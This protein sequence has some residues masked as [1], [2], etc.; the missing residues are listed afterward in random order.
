[1][2]EKMMYITKK[3]SFKDS[4]A[5]EFVKDFL[6]RYKLNVFVQFVK[7]HKELELLFRGNGDN[8]CVI[9]YRNNH[10]VWTI[11]KKGTEKYI[12]SIGLNI[13]RYTNDWYDKV[14]KFVCKYKEHYYK[15]LNKIP[16]VRKNYAF[17]KDLITDEVNEVTDEFVSDSYEMLKAFFDDYFN[18]EDL[19]KTDYIKSKYLND[20]YQKVGDTKSNDRPVKA[21]KI[22]QQ[23][24][25]SKILNGENSRY[26]A[27]D[28][29]FAQPYPDDEYK[30]KMIIGNNHPDMFAIKHDKDG[31]YKLVLVEVKSKSTSCNDHK[32]KN[33]KE[34]PGVI[35][36]LK[37][38]KSYLEEK[39]EFQYNNGDI[40]SKNLI[41]SRKDEAISVVNDYRKLCLRGFKKNKAPKY[42]VDF[43]NK[44]GKI[45]FAGVEILFIFT[46]LNLDAEFHYTPNKKSAIDWLNTLSLHKKTEIKNICSDLKNTKNVDVLFMTYS[47]SMK[48]YTL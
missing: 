32:N 33:G 24:L 10:R 17:D 18:F 46:D 41:E 34:I 20:H 25:F 38:M 13:A 22:L 14:Q 11:R 12:I 6:P 47:K 28:L 16:S 5:I 29:E 3:N 35:K 15:T 26:F 37:G 45:S 42:F 27:Y 36:H 44:D 9:I 40:Y 7:K 19:K 4:R 21:E 30:K 39:I 31:S 2:G 43:A 23:E 48:N 1:M 8:P